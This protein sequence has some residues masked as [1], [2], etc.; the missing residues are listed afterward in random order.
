MNFIEMI[1]GKATGLPRRVVLPEGTDPRTIAA[2]ALLQRLD[3]PQPVLLGPVDDIRRALD[4]AGADGASFSVIDPPSDPR[5]G[6]FAEL[7][8]QRRKEKGLT[9][10]EARQR[11]HDPLFFGAMM[12]QS[13]EVHAGVCG[14][15]NTTGDVM[16][17]GLWCIGTRAGVKTVSTSFYMVVP[18]FRGEAQEVLTF[19]D[20]ALVPDPT[21][22]Q[23]ADIAF[24]AAEARPKLVGDQPLVAFLSYST[25]GSAQGPL[26]DKVQQALAIF[27]EKHPDVAVD[28]ELQLDAALIA[29]VG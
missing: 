26:V 18:P 27:R 7:L 8:Y 20:C 28:G 1:R 24:A 6:D 19:T 4:A 21:A 11:V 22:E 12:L 9:P 16:R 25:K 13:G 2:A 23:L 29:S 17:A 14:A 5:L 3:L 15:V 10:E